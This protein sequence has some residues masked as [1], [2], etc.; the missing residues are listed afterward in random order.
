[1]SHTKPPEDDIKFSLGQHLQI[2]PVKPVPK[3][4]PKLSGKPVPAKI[5]DFYKYNRVNDF[6][7]DRPYQKGEKVN[8]I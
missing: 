4:P 2:F 3:I 1:M 8:L 7:Y 6:T 5:V